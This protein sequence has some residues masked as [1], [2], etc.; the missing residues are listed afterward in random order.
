MNPTSDNRAYLAPCLRH[1]TQ[2]PLWGTSD[3]LRTLNAIAERFKKML[4]IFS[5]ITI[6]SEMRKNYG[7]FA[8]REE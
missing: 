8:R 1:S 7:N 2:N 6:H 3:T 4:H 5:I